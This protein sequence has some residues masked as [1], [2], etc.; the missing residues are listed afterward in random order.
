M[1][2]HASLKGLALVAQVQRQFSAATAIA[3][4]S[5]SPPAKHTPWIGGFKASCGSGLIVFDGRPYPPIWVHVAW[6][7][8]LLSHAQFDHALLCV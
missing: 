6:D 5:K 1:L 4:P 3:D 8:P 7:D 2:I